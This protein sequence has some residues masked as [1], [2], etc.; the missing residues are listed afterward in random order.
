M[1]KLLFTSIVVLSALLTFGQQALHVSGLVQ[2]SS[3]TSLANHPVW[4][5]QYSNGSFLSQQKVYS[6]AWGYYN[7]TTFL[8]A[9]TTLEVMTNDCNGHFYANSYLATAT[10]TSFDDTL[11]IGCQGLPALNCMPNLTRLTSSTGLNLGLEDLNTTNSITNAVT[12]RYWIFGDGTSSTSYNVAN[13]SH[14]YSQSGTYSVCLIRNTVDTLNHIVYCEDT[15]CGSYSVSNTSP[16]AFCSSMFD[17]DTMASGGSSLVL[18]NR[19][20]PLHNNTS[21][22]TSYAWDF[23]DGSTSSQPFPSHTYTSLGLYP[24]CLTVTSVDSSQNV[25]TSSYCDTLGVD[26]AGNVLYK[27]SGAG[28]T[29]NVLNPNALEVAE[30]LGTTNLQVYPNPSSGRV[31]VELGYILKNRIQ[32]VIV[33]SR[34]QEVLAGAVSPNL[35][36]FIINVDPLSSGLY[37]LKILDGNAVSNCKLMVF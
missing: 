34:G 27:L 14:T 21:Y 1:K 17:V 31:T 4:V 32:W 6:D 30:L 15:L 28:F 11:R 18:Y 25:C 2:D 16:P 29:L 33:N 19:S 13:I 12:V 8:Q 10:D 37:Q 22:A 35:K 7:Y 36:S 3:N 9:S 26:S 23:G 5:N 24:I 20:T